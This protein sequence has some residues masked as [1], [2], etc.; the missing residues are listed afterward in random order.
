MWKIREIQEKVTNVVMNYSEVCI[1]FLVADTQLYRRLCR[2]VVYSS[3][4]TL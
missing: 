3:H 2:S 4:A 1:L